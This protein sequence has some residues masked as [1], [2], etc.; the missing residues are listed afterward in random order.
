MIN[1]CTRLTH[2]WRRS[3]RTPHTPG[4]RPGTS[5]RLDRLVFQPRRF[6]ALFGGVAPYRHRGRR[7]TEVPY[8]WEIMTCVRHES[9]RSARGRTP[10]G[11]GSLRYRLRST[12]PCA[13][14]AKLS[15]NHCALGALV[16]AKCTHKKKRACE[17]LQLCWLWEVGKKVRARNTGSAVNVPILHARAMGWD[18]TRFF[19]CSLTTMNYRR[20][21]RCVPFR[22]RAHFTRNILFTSRAR[23]PHR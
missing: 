16:G 20:P 15:H 19:V 11:A 13:M 23:C 14:R 3:P 12:H 6:L 1:Y 2:R 18:G 7:T 10:Q 9:E 17:M 8:L 5:R 4:P 22:T 21:Q